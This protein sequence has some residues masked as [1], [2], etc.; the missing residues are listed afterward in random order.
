MT[1]P[2]SIDTPSRWALVTALSPVVL[3]IALLLIAPGF[4][5]PLYL[6]PPEILGQPAGLV[7][8]G[9]AIVLAAVGAVVVWRS[10][11]PTV[12]AL[13]IGLLTI[14]ALLLIGLGPSIVGVLGN[15]SV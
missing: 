6:N 2:E 4:T 8:V 7:L 12:Q 1:S 15:V 9:L 3:W 13:A 5:D 14:P 11:S 10:R